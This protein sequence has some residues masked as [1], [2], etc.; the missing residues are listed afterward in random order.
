MFKVEKNNAKIGKY[1]ADIIDQKYKKRRRFCYAYIKATGEEPTEETLNNMSNR[2]SQIIQG[3]KSIQIYDLPYFTELLGIS[4]EQILS[5]GEFAAPISSR[6]TNYSVAC[7]KDPA[8]WEKHVNREDKLILNQDEYGK[9]FLDYA[10]ENNNYDLMKF[11]LDKNYIWF[12]CG[13]AKSYARNF[14][15]GTSIKRRNV[16]LQDTDLQNELITNDELR[17]KLI[18]LAVDNNDI[19][20]LERLRARESAE[21]YFIVNYLSGSHPDFN[22]SYN[23]RML[24]HISKS[25]NE[26]LDYFTDEFDVEN[27][28]P[29]VEGEKNNVFMYP[30]IGKLLDLLIANRSSFAET[31]IKKAIK[32]NNSTYKKLTQLVKKQINDQYY[33]GPYMKEACIQECKKELLL[34]NNASCVSFRGIYTS[35][36]NGIYY[37][38]IIT[39]I[40]KINKTSNNPIIKHLIEELNDSYEKII[41]LKDHLEEI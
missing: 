5:A 7:S 29:K 12:D 32:H 8:E 28:Y 34:S 18:T 30:F 36:T 4:C 3:K 37:D 6:A 23:E 25:S 2:I 26:V 41:N 24:H 9:T 17:L 39:N 15:A 1:L 16:L 31:A 22:K 27:I 33:E 35:E 38:G 14:G 19:D 13:N 20:V 40:V 21:M 10:L 11:L